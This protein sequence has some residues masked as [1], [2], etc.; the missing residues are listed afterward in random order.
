MDNN[1]YDTFNSQIRSVVVIGDVPTIPYQYTL[2]T[3]SYLESDSASIVLTSDLCDLSNL[4]KNFRQ[5]N[6]F[7]P[8]EI[9]TGWININKIYHHFNE[10]FYGNPSNDDLKRTIVNGEYKKFMTKRWSG[11]LEVPTWNYGNV[12][13]PDLLILSCTEAYT[14]LEDYLYEFKFEGDQ[15]KVGYVLNQIIK[16]VTGFKIT[17]DEELLKNKDIMNLDLGMKEKLNKNDGEVSTV[18]KGYNTIGKTIMQVIQDVCKKARIDF[19]QDRSKSEISYIF[20]T[21][22][23]SDKLWKLDRNGH[24]DTLSI[25]GG[26]HGRTTG[27]TK[28]GVIVQSLNESTNQVVNGKFPTTLTNANS[29]MK[30]KVVKAENNLNQE[31]CEERASRIALNYAKYNITG[32]MTIPNAITGI[33]PDHLLQI[34]DTSPLNG[35]NT[36]RKITNITGKNDNSINFRINSIEESFGNGKCEQSLEFELDISNNLNL[37]DF[38]TGEIKGYNLLP[39]S[40]DVKKLKEEQEQTVFIPLENLTPNLIKMRENQ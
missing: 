1:R 13:S 28:I 8:I 39:D 38:K 19:I 18:D 40:K 25:Y 31:Q 30:I 29:S 21:K 16:D 22:K 12:S 3:N 4:W 15:A 32:K 10:A 11:I 27:N 14:L 6:V 20:K 24:F 36:A 23:S 17:I 5:E 34:L 37:I 33:E 9:W 35:Y 2:T 7:V 26:K